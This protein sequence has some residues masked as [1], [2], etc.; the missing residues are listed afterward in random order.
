MSGIVSDG[1]FF[2]NHHWAITLQNFRS[3]HKWNEYWE[4][5]ATSKTLDGVEFV[6]AVQSKQYPYFITQFHP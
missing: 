3:N 4:L 5:I 1:I 6:A 2:Y